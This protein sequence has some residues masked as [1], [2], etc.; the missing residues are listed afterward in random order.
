ME[1][2][3][4]VGGH[5]LGAVHPVSVRPGTNVMFVK[6]RLLGIGLLL[7]FQGHLLGLY[8]HASFLVVSG[9]G[10]TPFPTEAPEFVD[11]GAS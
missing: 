9:L 7:L 10:A 5:A 11:V 6:Q 8:H 2:V 3:A 4:L 1:R